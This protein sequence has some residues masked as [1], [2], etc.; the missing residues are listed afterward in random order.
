MKSVEANIQKD[1]QYHLQ[2]HRSEAICRGPNTSVDAY[3][4]MFLMLLICS[5]RKF[6]HQ[7][8]IYWVLIYTRVERCN[9]RRKG[10]HNILHRSEIRVEEAKDKAIR[11]KRSRK[12]KRLN[13]Q[14]TGYL[15]A[16]SRPRRVG[17]EW[18]QKRW[19]AMRSVPANTADLESPDGT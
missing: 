12:D 1:A 7:V 16:C 11:G 15:S 9:V 17:R 14:S 6:I 4:R 5:Y 8:I 19:T 18:R 13:I 3:V 2:L 10:S